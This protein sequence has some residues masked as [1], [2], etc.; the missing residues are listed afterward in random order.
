MPV[1][2]VGKKA[3]RRKTRA[4]AYKV[5]LYRKSTTDGRSPDGSRSRSLRPWEG[6]RDL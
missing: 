5:K 2:V 1:V 3:R 4:R 6:C